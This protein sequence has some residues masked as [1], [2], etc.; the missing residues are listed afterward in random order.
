MSI[1][2]N[3]NKTNSVPTGLSDLKQ[4]P[5]DPKKF[6]VSILKIKNE[7]G[8]GVRL[9]TVNKKVTFNLN[10]NNSQ[11][12]HHVMPNYM[13]ATI[14][15]MAKKVQNVVSKSQNHDLVPLPG[16]TSIY[17]QKQKMQAYIRR[18]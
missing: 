18:Y 14:S 8:E 5:N 7:T 9:N 2:L 12:I 16:K 13:K 11:V 4:S 3:F 10:E 6:L 17:I 1:S 15:S